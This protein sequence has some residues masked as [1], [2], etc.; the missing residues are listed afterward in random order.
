MKF[1]TPLS[2]LKITALAAIL[3]TACE[4]CYD[5]GPENAYPYFNL[6][7]LNKTSLDTLRT[8]SS[9]LVAEIKAIDNLIKDPANA[10]II[11]SLNSEKTASQQS[12]TYIKNLI[13]TTKNRLISIHSING[14]E[15]LFINQNGGDSLT[16][17]KIP[18]NTNTNESEYQIQIEGANF[19]N[20][21][22]I[23]Y[24]LSD[25]VLNSK[26]TKKASNLQVITHEFES[27]ISPRGCT[28]IIECS[29][30]ELQIYVEI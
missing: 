17:F 13:T 8:D 10:P 24:E 6:S 25:T 28:P 2:F 29:S 30:N 27:L 11:D 16:R 15:G 26:I 4:P 22:K 9:A 21:L 5:C 19:E 14:E 7:I 18:I 1:N 3:F 23:S 20:Y 12:L